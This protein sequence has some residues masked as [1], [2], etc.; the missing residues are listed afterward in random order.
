[1]VFAGMLPWFF[2]ATAVSEATNSLSS[3]GA[4]VAKIYFPR[5]IIPLSSVLVSLVDYLIS[6]LLIIAIMVWTG[7]APTLRLL[8]FPLLT[9]WVVGLA[10]AVGIW[11]A[12]MTVRYRDLRHLIPFLLQLGIYVSPVGYTASIVP[13]RWRLLY[14]LNPMVGIIDGYRWALLGNEF[15]AFLP[16]VLF[17]SLVT[18]LF[19]IF[20]IAYFRKVERTFVDFL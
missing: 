6:C 13:E 19:L 17:S 4:L 2:F 5:L 1:M 16:G 7:T 14:S 15:T 12:A 10:L 11:A 20:G 3:N 18:V 8:V 9:L